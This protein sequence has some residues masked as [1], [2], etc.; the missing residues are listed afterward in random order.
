MELLKADRSVVRFATG[1]ALLAGLLMLLAGCAGTRGG[2]I[3]YDV[4][5]FGKPDE[6]VTFALEDGYKIAPMDTLKITVFKM[7]DLSG[8]YQVDLTGRISLPLLGEVKAVDMTTAEL[9]AVLTEKYGE[10]YLQSPDVSVGIKSSTRRNVTVDGSVRQ[11]GIFQVDGPMTLMQAVA[12]ARGADENANPKRVAIF[13]QI[14]GKRSAAAFD[15]TSIRKGE[16]EDPAVYAGDIIVVDGSAIKAAQKQLMQS[17]PF[18][19]FLPI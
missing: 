8:E 7:A 15:L 3:P 5:D 14:K 6:P 17:V 16:M 11:P 4:Q 2:P 19:A 1:F 12:M 13:R 10:K 18:F 9:D